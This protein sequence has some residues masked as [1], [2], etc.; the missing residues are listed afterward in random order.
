MGAGMPASARFAA[1]ACRCL[2]VSG[3]RG[4][5]RLP[6]AAPRELLQQWQ[7]GTRL[8]SVCGPPRAAGTGQWSTV[9]AGTA[10]QCQHCRPLTRKTSA[11][12]FRQPGGH[13]H[14]PPMVPN[15]ATAPV[16]AGLDLGHS[17]VKDAYMTSE[18][19]SV[20]KSGQESVVIASFDSYRHA[21]HMLASLGRG[22][23]KKARKSGTTAVVVRGNTD[24]SLKVKQ[25]R[26][27]TASD[28]A[29]TLI[30]LS[31]SWT[32]GLIGLGATLKG[33]KSQAHAAHVHKRHVGSD[34]HRT[35]KILAEAGPNAAIALVRCKDQET[36][37]MVAAAAADSARASWDGSLTEFLAAL[38]PGSTDDWVRAALGEPSSTNR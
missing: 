25:S 4:R 23:R 38:D 5:S 18:A 14:V 1:I 8:A 37:Q 2:A 19:N 17:V 21:E 36:R 35:H 29:S 15:T 13:C 27:L 33:A 26:V 7:H 10:P 16:V 22:F 6:N 31:V 34:A 9:V 20:A 24:G 12:I 3:R 32:V 30:S 28:F 11:R